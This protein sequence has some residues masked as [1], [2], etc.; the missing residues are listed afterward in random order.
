[1]N[2]AFRPSLQLW[3]NTIWVIQIGN[4]ENNLNQIQLF[5]VC[6][7]CLRRSVFVFT[8]SNVIFLGSELN[9]KNSYVENLK[10][11]TLQLIKVSKSV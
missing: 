9:L 11:K 4:F 8:S 6:A 5:H 1:M 2:P 10:Y 3:Q 7:L